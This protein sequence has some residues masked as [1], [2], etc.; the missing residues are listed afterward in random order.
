MR[1]KC[2]LACKVPYLLII[3]FIS[4]YLLLKVARDGR[5]LSRN[6]LNIQ[7]RSLP[8]QTHPRIVL[9][10]VH[11]STLELSSPVRH[12]KSDSG[13]LMALSYSDQMTGSVANLL[14][15]QCLGSSLDQNSQVVEPFLDSS[16]LGVDA[17][18]R[19]DENCELSH[20][21]ESVKLTD[22]LNTDHWPS[23]KMAPLVPW[24]RFINNAP[25]KLISVDRMCDGSHSSSD[26]TSLECIKGANERFNQS[27]RVL[28]RCYGFE[29]VRRVYFT[30]NRSYSQSQFKQLIYQNFLPQEVAVIFHVWGG[31]E[32]GPFR[33]QILVDECK[34]AKFFH[35]WN[36]PQHSKVLL[37]DA[38]RYKQMYIS[39]NRSNENYISIMVRLEHFYIKHNKF[40]GKSKEAILTLL[41]HLYRDIIKQVHSLKTITPYC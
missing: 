2:L 14:S 22:V 5:V 35:L 30:S 20:V 32:N 9:S 17:A 38:S 37:A 23:E 6:S 1:S 41:H 15:L 13:Y 28:E 33:A 29:E 16:I 12:N 8:E 27:I 19:G 25:Q 11:H 39:E 34:R 18:H 40:Q 3:L 26:G 21:A 4:V 36:A 24:T 10:M 31:I 7:I